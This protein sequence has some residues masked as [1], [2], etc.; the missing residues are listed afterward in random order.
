MGILP[1]NRKPDIKMVLKAVSK[2]G[3]LQHQMTLI[4]QLLQGHP[5]LA[6]YCLLFMH[7]SVQSPP[8]TM[9]RAQ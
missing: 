1:V 4:A 5:A 8:F 7:T 3:A 2:C 6:S 9:S